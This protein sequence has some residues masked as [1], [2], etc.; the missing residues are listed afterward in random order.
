MAQAEVGSLRVT[1]GMNAGE[2]NRKVKESDKNL[3]RLKR[4]F[5]DL[6][7][8]MA[9][10]FAAAS[11]VGVLSKA[12]R[13]WGIQEKAIASV[14]ATL[15]STGN[16]AGF[17]SKQLQDMAS[18]LQNVST[19]GDE[20]ILQKLTNNLLTFGNITGPVFE[21]AQKMALGLSTVLNQD[22]QSSAIQLGKALNDPLKGITAL[23]RVGIA[24]TD[25]QKE[26]IKTLLQANE[27]W[28][29]QGVILEEIEKFYGKAATA[30][31]KTSSGALTAAGN[32][33]GDAF[34]KIG[35]DIAPI[36]IA[37]ANA[38][39]SIA[40]SFQSLSSET[41]KFITVFT[42]LTATVTAVV[43]ALSLFGVSLGIAFAPLTAIIAGIA[44]LGAAFY[45]FSPQI[46]ETAKIVSTMFGNIYEAAK[47]YL[48]TGLEPILKGMRNLFSWAWDGVKD[49]FINPLI[50]SLPSADTAFKSIYTSAKTWLVD[51]FDPI[52]EWFRTFVSQIKS[53]LQELADFAGIAINFDAIQTSMKNAL[54]NAFD[55]TVNEVRIGLDKI[56]EVWT[57]G[58][59]EVATVT[60]E[61]VAK[62]KE[63]IIAVK[64]TMTDAEKEILASQKRLVDEG[65]RLTEGL[66]TPYDIMKDKVMAL[67]A[68]QDAGK[69]TA[70][71]YGAAQSQAANIATS[72]YAG[73][74]SD[75]SSS[76]ESVFGESKA[77]AIV[78]AII[79][80]YEGFTK[81]LAAYPPPF[82][83]AAA[84]AVLASGLAKVAAI[85][86][87]NKSS[88][89]GGG[90][91]GSTASASGGGR[92][93]VPA[94]GTAQSLTV[95]GIDPG[96][97]FSGETVRELAGKLIEFQEDG[98]KVI[99]Q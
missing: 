41:R 84:G 47:T 75:I 36:V 58:G 95:Q 19:F 34:E 79:N 51:A 5:A 94:A 87:T 77:F 45:A 86:R 76:L 68:A 26:Q 67:K 54:K 81:A 20:E 1:M 97:L 64:Q 63:P 98:G 13:L 90:G 49:E 60:S 21:K 57:K 2:F 69:I 61:A 52:I 32:D 23:S 85:K 46:V 91:G 42:G 44:A 70:A 38:S 22:L 7:A 72:A 80:S 18:E 25:E 6:G 56:K 39:S 28:K 73:M 78:S 17:T 30:V 92:S 48:L 83:Y 33:I 27:T 35:Q 9:S 15:R 53:L 12:T 62:W 59:E 10:A 11:F 65:V 50:K 93:A 24:F 96:A 4:R 55:F 29:A 89:G 8:T 31:R 71:Q 16:S 37:V 3:A 66:K 99:I 88:S 43:G 14:E 40:K 82:N 74:A